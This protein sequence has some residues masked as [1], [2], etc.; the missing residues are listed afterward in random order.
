MQGIEVGASAH[1]RYWLNTLNVDRWGHIDNSIYKREERRL[2]LHSAK[3]DLVA[4]GDILPFRDNSHEFVFASH[5]LEHFPDPI[6]ALE[7]WHRVA[8]NV[9]VAVVPHKD[10]TFDVDRP[11]STVAELVERHRGGL[12]P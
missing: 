7:E 2:V 1:N 12:R 5:V 11:L 4:R 9:I 3:V 6:R 8:S 10:R